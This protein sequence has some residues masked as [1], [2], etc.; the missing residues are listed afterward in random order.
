LELVKDAQ[1]NTLR[2]INDSWT[3]NIGNLESGKAY[4]I[5]VS[6][7]SSFLY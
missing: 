6:Q 5:K 1:G 7:D 3:N 2:K 4:L